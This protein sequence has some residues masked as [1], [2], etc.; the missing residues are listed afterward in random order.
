M[1]L[2]QASGQ[3]KTEQ[4]R[5]LREAP[6]DTL[7]SFILHELRM[8]IRGAL[9]W[10]IVPGLYVG[11]MVAAYPSLEGQLQIENYPEAF[12]EAF[13]ITDL[14]TVGGFLSAQFFNWAPLIL[15]F[16]P[17]LVLSGAIAGAEERGTIDILLG[18]PLPRWQ[19][20]LGNF[21][22]TAISL[23]G[24]LAIVGLFAWIAAALAGVDLS[25]GRAF[26]AALNLW[27][28]CLFFGGLA[29]LCSA[30]FRRRVLAIAVPA[31]VLFGMYLIDV[32]GDLAEEVEA[33]QPVSA[34]HYYGSAITEGIDWAD[35]VGFA[36]AA[37][38]L[39]VLAALAFR[40]RD[41]YT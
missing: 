2:G 5:A 18:N 10:G 7:W 38:V 19:L 37:L 26:E 32:L 25:F 15:A 9:V 8:R 31:A 40:R 22:A 39:A 13:G 33:L 30:L 4:R 14:G 35:F 23:L 6:R 21:V 34:F 29:L 20:V 16:F 41:I 27:P 36:L 24:A 3:R 12:R 17:I 1:S 11:A 28:I